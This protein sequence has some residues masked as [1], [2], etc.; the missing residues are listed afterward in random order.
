MQFLRVVMNSEIVRME[1]FIWRTR[2]LDDKVL[3]WRAKRETINIESAIK[4]DAAD[5]QGNNP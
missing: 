3:K 1:K 5:T 4:W 2:K